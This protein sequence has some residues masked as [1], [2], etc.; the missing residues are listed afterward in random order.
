MP[1]LKE[2]SVGFDWDSAI[3]IDESEGQLNRA[4]AFDF[5]WESARPEP[6]PIGKILKESAKEAAIETGEKVLQVLSVIRWPFWR[7]IE[8]PIGVIGEAIQDPEG[9]K[10]LPTLARAVQAYVPFRRIPKE[11]YGSYGTIWNN[12]YKATF[13]GN[14]APDWY[15]AMASVGTAIG[16]E[17]GI[18]RLAA[19][20][21]GKAVTRVATPSEAKI[22]NK[23]FAPFK[24]S[25]EK[26]GLDPSKLHPEGN[27]I[28]LT[29]ESEL[30]MNKYVSAVIKGDTIRVPRW[31][32]IKQLPTVVTKPG[33]TPKAIVPTPPKI[34]PTT[35]PEVVL[36][37][38]PIPKAPLKPE[39]FI[40]KTKQYKNIEG[41]IKAKGL[42]PDSIDIKDS[43]NFIVK[44][45]AG[46]DALLVEIPIE[47]FGKPKFETLAEYEPKPE[48]KITDPIEATLEEGKLII[49][50]GANRFTQAVA[51]GDK[52]IPVILEVAGKV[53]P[54]VKAEVIPKFKSTEEAEAFGKKATPGQIEGLKQEKIKLQEE[55]KTLEAAGKE[56]EAFTLAT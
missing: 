54:E 3:P 43:E 6:K 14:D 41:F 33:V 21:V 5:D 27:I 49:T 35:G 45:T 31:A 18:T 36:T 24:A 9:K 39:S 20:G 51:N 4:P 50:D 1:E 26:R 48:R 11:E 32:K 40:E 37:P 7:F 16:I 28:K 29:E 8:H 25:L 13:N 22:I 46:K 55:F 23:A 19:K 38:P 52:T 30:F 10:V 47:Q 56:S 53:A 15:I 12:Y 34:L 2:P 44:N 42:D 17:P